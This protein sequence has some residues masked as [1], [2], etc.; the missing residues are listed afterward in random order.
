MSIKEYH[1]ESFYRFSCVIVLW[2]I[3]PQIPGH[4][5][6]VWI[7]ACECQFPGST[8]EAVGYPGVAVIGS[9]ELLPDTVLNSVPLEEQRI[10][11]IHE[12]SLQT[13][14]L[15]FKVN[16]LIVSTLKCSG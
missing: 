13:C 9:C 16:I 8:E 7:G 15:I 11:F 12:S 2:A 4:L 6:C 1:K 3:H 5:F 10:L 14:F